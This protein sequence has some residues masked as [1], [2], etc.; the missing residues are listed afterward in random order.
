V[1]PPTTVQGWSGVG[2]GEEDPGAKADP[3]IQAELARLREL[4]G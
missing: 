2:L 4:A 1:S 3:E